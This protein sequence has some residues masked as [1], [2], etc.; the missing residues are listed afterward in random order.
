MLS[1]SNTKQVPH[2]ARSLKGGQFKLMPGDGDSGERRTFRGIANSGEMMPDHFWWG[3]FIL[4]MSG[5]QNDRRRPVLLN[6]DYDKRAGHTGFFVNDQMQLEIEDGQLLSNQYGSSIAKDSD[7]DFPWEMSVGFDPHVIE[8]LQAGQETTV[9]GHQVLG[10]A[11][12]MRQWALDEVSFTPV[13]FDRNTEAEALSDQRKLTEVEIMK[14]SNDL[15]GRVIELTDKAKSL[16]GERDDLKTQLQTAMDKIEDLTAQ[17]QR[18]NVITML[19]ELDIEAE[20][21]EIDI[22]AS[23]DANQLA[24]VKTRLSKQD[25]DGGGPEASKETNLSVK[26]GEIHRQLTSQTS[27]N[28]P[29]SDATEP[30]PIDSVQLAG[31]IRKEIADQSNLG[32]DI[33]A[34]EAELIIRNR[35]NSNG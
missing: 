20:D 21:A 15:S 34:A 31:K 14:D 9:N 26:A 27:L 35:E 23:M 3:N 18:Q 32:N 22:Y 10:P 13:G 6:H 29:D 11:T 12:I 24:V 16:S 7:E 28:V 17:L 33:G 4:D 5:L 30:A 19:A 25:G 1:M 8:E 2:K